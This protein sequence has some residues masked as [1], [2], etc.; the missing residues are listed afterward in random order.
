MADETKE[1]ICFNCAYFFTASREATE[2]GICLEDD[3]FEPY[4]DELLEKLNFAVCQD[5]IEKKKFSGESKGCERYEEAE[6]LEF[7]D[8][9][10]LGEMMH[11]FMETGEMDWERF[12]DKIY[13]KSLENR[14]WGKQVC[15]YRERLEKGDRV[16]QIEALRSLG[17]IIPLG[18]GEAFDALLDYLERQP[19][20]EKIDDVHV[21]IDVLES[22]G[23]W[24]TAD[25]KARLISLLVGELYKIVSNNT[26]RQWITKILNYLAQCPEAEVRLPLETL[27]REREFSPKMQN[28]ISALLGQHDHE[29][30]F[31]FYE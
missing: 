9:S 20:P 27:L 14:D 28:K 26:T 22:L 6:T 15:L 2:Y 21:K 18:S 4:I 17:G 23:Y 7:D 25:Q 1:R 8:D 16:E 3:D 29:D 12:R 13:I 30:Y 10:P 24:G 19:P 5:L 11:H 31:Y